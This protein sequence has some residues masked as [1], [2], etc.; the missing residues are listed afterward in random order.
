MRRHIKSPYDSQN[1]EECTADV[2]KY[3]HALVSE[4]IEDSRDGRGV[5]IDVNDIIIIIDWMI[6]FSSNQQ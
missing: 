5:D 3:T 2:T 6:I 4:L 1:D